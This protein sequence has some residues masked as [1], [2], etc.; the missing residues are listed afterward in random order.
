MQSLAILRAEPKIS[1][2]FP[3]SDRDVHTYFTSSSI[4]TKQGSN[5]RA[6]A[7]LEALFDLTSD[8]LQNKHATTIAKLV[9]STDIEFNAP[10]KFSDLAAQ[11]RRFMAS[12][13]DQRRHGP[14]RAWFYK[15]AVD[16]ATK[17]VGRI[18]TTSNK[19][20]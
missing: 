17:L 3:P 14:F 12:G 11:F 2:G 1:S 18:F 20:V 6:E 9:G 13:M 7:F 5:R 10:M 15:T 8:T 19:A 16:M 4:D